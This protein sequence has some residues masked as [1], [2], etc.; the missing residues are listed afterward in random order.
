MYGNIPDLIPRSAAASVISLYEIMGYPDGP[1]PDPISWENSGQ[2][3]VTS[4]DEW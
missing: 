2:H 1:I 4:A 3:T